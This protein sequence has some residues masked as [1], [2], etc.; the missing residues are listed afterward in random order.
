MANPHDQFGAQLVGDILGRERSFRIDSVNP[1]KVL[2][3]YPG[4]KWA[5]LD[6]TPFAVAVKPADAE[7]FF[8]SV[9]SVDGLVKA[10]RRA[11][12]SKLFEEDIPVACDQVSTYAFEFLEKILSRA[13]QVLEDD[14]ARRIASFVANLDLYSAVKAVESLLN[15]QA[16]LALLKLA[17]MQD[18]TLH[19]D[20][21]AIRCGCS[22]RNDAQRVVENLQRHHGYAPS[23]LKGE[24][25][26][27]FDD[28]WDAY[29]LYKML[30]NGQQLRLFIDQ[31]TLDNNSQIIQHWNHVYGYTAHHLA[32]RATRFF[33]D[34]RIEVSLSELIRAVKGFGLETMIPTGEYTKGLLEQ[35]FTRPERNQDIPGNIRRRLRQIDESLEGS[36]ENGKLLELL[37]RREIIPEMKPAYFSLYGIT[38]KNDNPLHSAPIYPYFLPSQAAHVIRTSVNVQG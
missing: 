25:Y 37:S 13:F 9:T 4:A 32:I 5:S 22:G 1:Q 19:F 24:N 23:Q 38:F 17:E 29:I 21:L 11:R 14:D 27:R 6:L 33:Q 36:I 18:W 34:R 3:P 2:S 15:S 26:Y 30:D 20:H 8:S 10:Y 31:S 16:D 7:G 12:R 35:V 28:G